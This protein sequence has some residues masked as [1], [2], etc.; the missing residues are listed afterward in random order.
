MRQVE[1]EQPSRQ[2][3]LWTWGNLVGE[4][5]PELQAWGAMLGHIGAW[6]TPRGHLALS[7]WARWQAEPH[8]KELLTSVDPPMWATQ[9]GRPWGIT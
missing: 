3:D 7:P 6:Q 2:G 8:M 1:K 9:A 5:G 4:M